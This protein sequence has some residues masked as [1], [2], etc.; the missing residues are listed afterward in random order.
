MVVKIVRER[1]GTPSF[2]VS[3]IEA[4]EALRAD[5]KAQERGGRGSSRF[6]VLLG[7]ADWIV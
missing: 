4:D 2:L 7:A 6:I 3:R 5:F 1:T